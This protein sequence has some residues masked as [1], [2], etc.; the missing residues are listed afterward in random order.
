M[1]TDN[2]VLIADWYSSDEHTVYYL[3]DGGSGPGPSDQYVLEGKTFTLSSYSG[4][5]TNYAFDGWY[6]SVDQKVYP[7][8]STFTM[9]NK[10]MY[11][12]ANWKSVVKHNVSFDVGDGSLPAPNSFQVYE[13]EYFTLPSYNGTNGDYIFS[14]WCLE[15][16]YNL[17]P[18]GDKDLMGNADR[19][20]V[21]QWVIGNHVTGVSLNKI[22]VTID[23]TES[24]TLEA[25]ISPYDAAIKDVLWS[26]SD[27]SVATVD[28]GEVTAVG[29]GSAIITARSADGNKTAT[30]TVTVNM[31]YVKTISVSAPYNN[32]AIGS[33]V[34]MS[35]SIY[36]LETTAQIIWSSSDNSIATV[37]SNGNVNCLK[38]GTVTIKV[39]AGGKTAQSTISIGES[40]VTSISLTTTVAKMDSG[41]TLKIN[42]M[43]KPSDSAV[44][45]KWISS[46]PKVAT[47][48]ENGLV[49]AVSSGTATITAE[50]DGKTAQAVITVP[51]I[52]VT[53]VTLSK[54]SLNL[55]VGDSYDLQS[56]V[57][58]NN[59]TNKEV[60]W[61][62]SD[63]SVV[64][65]SDGKVKAIKEGSATITVTTIDG[66]K[67]ATCTVKVDKASGS[68]KL[69]AT[70][71]A[72]TN[73]G[74][75]K[76]DA[77]VTGIQNP[78]I[79]WT[80]SD[81]SVVTIDS[82]GNYS[83]RSIGT[84]TITASVGNMKATCSITVEP[85]IYD[86]EVEAVN[87]VSVISNPE[88]V[89]AYLRYDQENRYNT[90][91]RVI[92]KDTSKASVQEDI[93]IELCKMDNAELRVEINGFLAVFPS[94]MLQDYTGKG[95]LT[96][97]MEKTKLPSRFNHLKAAV[98]IE[99]DMDVGGTKMSNN[100]NAPVE[101]SFKYKWSSTG[102]IPTGV[103]AY[104]L[105]ENGN[106]EKL[107]G[108]MGWNGTAG[109][110][111]FTVRHFSTYA[112]VFS[113]SSDQMMEPKGNMVLPGDPDY[114][115]PSGGGSSDS[116][117]SGSGSGGIDMTMIAIAGAAALALIAIAAVVILRRR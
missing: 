31:N 44:S 64:S 65:V 108:G 103:N 25:T 78:V 29:P 81:P 100:F 6:Y 58:P 63:S 74:K 36:P 106:E 89:K 12:E 59:A 46:D 88:T 96:V 53:S 4:T 66:S 23:Y 13:E 50:A 86:A 34:E 24:Y 49:T 67:T 111:S 5:K 107:G 54:S 35:C 21:A 26:S 20:Y 70:G 11:F 55:L 62:S 17:I 47:V 16:Q 45:V 40:K 61:K 82:E 113:D 98:V 48:D 71:I 60:D 99:V 68:I 85:R 41:K 93:L 80:S 18:P 76:I 91:L 79:Q 97:H 56:T 38:S 101:I 83:A 104:Y 28:N 15:G 110:I 42:A 30:C 90:S 2:I 14:G 109:N 33:V 84:V 27:W 1:G 52:K 51:A 115:N 39:Q 112:I 57:S 105:P 92:A 9:G 69:S 32:V 75:G 7:V 116:N 19:K 3:L 8:G 72:L 87:G 43:L 117:S 73:G 22:S 102:Q 114:S 37:D 10:D 77:T 95:D 94:K